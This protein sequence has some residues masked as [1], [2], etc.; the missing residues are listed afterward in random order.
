[1]SAESVTTPAIARPA[2]A[3]QGRGASSSMGALTPSASSVPSWPIA[4]AMRR[5]FGS[6]PGCPSHRRAHSGVRKAY[7]RKLT[8]RTARGRGA[9]KRRGVATVAMIVARA[10]A[11]WPR[12]QSWVR[13]TGSVNA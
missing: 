6:L 3:V 13:A 7:R 4:T 5:Y 8:K 1:M 2:I 12:L 11:S 9:G 10:A